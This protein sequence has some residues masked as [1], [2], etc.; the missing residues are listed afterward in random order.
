[1]V[2]EARAVPMVVVMDLVVEVVDMIAE[3]SKRTQKKRVTVLSR[4]ESELVRKAAGYFEI[5]VCKSLP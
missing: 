3:D 1:M 2:E 4:R 5:F